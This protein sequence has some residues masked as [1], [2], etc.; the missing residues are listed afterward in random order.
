[1]K[2][3]ERK[4]SGYQ[5]KLEDRVHP[6]PMVGY[7]EVNY[8]YRLHDGN[9]KQVIVSRDVVFDETALSSTEATQPTSER[10]PTDFVEFDTWIAGRSS[11]S[12]ES[13]SGEPSRNEQGNVSV[14]SDARNLSEARGCDSPGARPDEHDTEPEG[15]QQSNVTMSDY[16]DAGPASPKTWELYKLPAGRKPISSRWIFKKK[17]KA[18]GELDNSKACLVA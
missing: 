11:D 14:N 2:E 6:L 5:Q 12:E 17:Y 10:A 7:R 3:Q 1:M 18:N 16:I 13:A 4:R 15:G 8:T 9:T